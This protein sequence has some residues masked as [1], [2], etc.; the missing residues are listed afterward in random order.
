MPVFWCW[1]TWRAVSWSTSQGRRWAACAPWRVSYEGWFLYS[2]HPHPA[3]SSLSLFLAIFWVPYA[4]SIDAQQREKSINQ[5]YCVLA[6]GTF[7]WAGISSVW[8]FVCV[9]VCAKSLQSCLT[10][11]DPMDYSLTGSFIHG[12]F[13]ART[14]E[15]IAI[16]FSER[17]CM[18]QLGSGTTK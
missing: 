16:A 15:W 3:F 18:L 2:A 1:S 13:Q 8:V 10:L 4:P 7:Q 14:L 12:I 17:S 11:C 5:C 9:C 6:K